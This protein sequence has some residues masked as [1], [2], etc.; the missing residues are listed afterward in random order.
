MRNRLSR[1]A[2]ARLTLFAAIVLSAVSLLGALSRETARA[3][4]P[5]G[6]RGV[7]TILFEKCGV[8]HVYACSSF[9]DGRV[10][11]YFAGGLFAQVAW[12]NAGFDLHRVEIPMQGFVGEGRL[13]SG[14]SARNILA[15]SR[16]P[17]VVERIFENVSRGTSGAERFRSTL[18]MRLRELD[19]FT[20]D[21]ASGPER[22]RR[23]SLRLDDSL[24]GLRR[25]EV[26]YAPSIGV[27]IGEAYQSADGRLI[28]RRPHAILRPGD[29]GFLS[30]SGAV[31][32][33]G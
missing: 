32:C 29:E 14:P 16:L 4:P 5:E 7:A 8:G 11:Y 19:P 18:E 25:G 1:R 10:V 33:D 27:L 17:G 30:I 26:L 23:F 9:P 20:I 22:V 31:E 6:C 13:A 12:L 15:S 21:L 3:G 24:T 2:I 28:E